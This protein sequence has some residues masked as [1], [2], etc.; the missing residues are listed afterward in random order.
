MD[1]AVQTN[2][3]IIMFNNES[4]VEIPQIPYVRDNN[5]NGFPILFQKTL[6]GRDCYKFL[7]RLGLHTLIQNVKFANIDFNCICQR[8]SV[9]SGTNIC[10]HSWLVKK[11]DKNVN[12]IPNDKNSHFSSEFDYTVY[13][14]EPCLTYS[15]NATFLKCK[16]TLCC[17]NNTMGFYPLKSCKIILPED[18]SGSYTFVSIAKNC[19]SFVQNE[20]FHTKCTDKIAVTLHIL[21]DSN[22][23]IINKTLKSDIANKYNINIY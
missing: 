21:I 19:K 2:I 20:N 12:I 11:Y 17:K 14:L 10:F 16:T 4:P 8:V 5:D 13:P 15:H 23:N 22:A 9:S 18:N 7:K 3:P 6:S 1:P